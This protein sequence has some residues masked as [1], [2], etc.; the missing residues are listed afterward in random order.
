MTKKGKRIVMFIGVIICIALVMGTVA[1]NRQDKN[2]A[3][4]DRLID[5]NLFLIPLQKG[6]RFAVCAVSEEKCKISPSMIKKAMDEI[7]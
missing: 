7:K 4:V 3:I 6:L 1:L 5:E 2:S